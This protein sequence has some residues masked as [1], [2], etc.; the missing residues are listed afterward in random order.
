VLSTYIHYLF[1]LLDQSALEESQ[2]LREVLEEKRSHLI[3]VATHGA[4]IYEI[5]QRISVI[6]P[7]YHVTLSQ[8]MV[9]IMNTL[10]QQ[11]RGKGSTGKL[12]W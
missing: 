8:Y 1:C 11:H 3:V 5:I 10:Q 12:G 6:D 9:I 7:L 2:Y 4:K